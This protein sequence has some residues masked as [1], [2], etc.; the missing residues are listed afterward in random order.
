MH[1]RKAAALPRTSHLPTISVQQI[2]VSSVL[3]L[4]L[5]SAFTLQMGKCSE[6]VDTIF[7]HLTLITMDPLLMISYNKLHLTHITFRF[8]I[9]QSGHTPTM[10]QIQKESELR[11][12]G[13]HTPI[14]FHL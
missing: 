7:L 8:R 11:P 5:V 12:R 13:W 2:L 14:H 9:T 3:L 6:Y 4:P 10:A 1:R